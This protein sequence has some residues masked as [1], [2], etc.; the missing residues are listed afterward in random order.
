MAPTVCL[1]KVLPEAWG[2]KKMNQKFVLVG[3]TARANPT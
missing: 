2:V 1:H 3:G